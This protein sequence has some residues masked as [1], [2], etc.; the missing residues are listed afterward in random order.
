[1]ASSFKQIVENYGKPE[2]VLDH[3]VAEAVGEM[4]FLTHIL[5]PG[6]NFYFWFT[7]S[8][9]LWMK[10]LHSEEHNE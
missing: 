8:H 4:S 3:C 7:C 1:M 10:G 2:V 6:S 5:L 9:T